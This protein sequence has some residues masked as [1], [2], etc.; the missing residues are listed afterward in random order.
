MAATEMR[1]RLG[2]DYKNGL[3]V[4]T[5]H[6]LANYMLCSAGIDT[7][8]IINEEKF[9]RLFE[10]VEAH[11]NAV[12]HLDW[13]LLDEAQDT[14]ALQFK[15]L[16]KMINPDYFF[17]I[18]DLRQSIYRWRG[19]RPDL[20]KTMMDRNDVAVY[21]LTENYRNGANI[22]SFA[23][24][25]IKKIGMDDNSCPMR[26]YRGIVGEHPYNLNLIVNEVNKCFAYKDCAVIARENKTVN[27]VVSYLKMNGIPCES[28]KQ[29]DL[30]KEELTERME[31]DTVKVLTVHAS[32][33]LE[34]P[35]VI[36][37]GMRFWNEEEY[38]VA[39]VA[40]TRARDQLIWMN[41]PSKKRF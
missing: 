24:R 12:K 27:E 15:F 1:E 4:G 17:I 20:L 2:E 10:M 36:A 22:L 41:A 28:F 38:N 39:Y 37:I 14:D 18:G 8:K 13:I 21:D 31:S 34:W 11:P 25:I 32:K 5:I 23:K 26:E 9:D 19:A 33:G 7:K 16:F 29:G 3:F 40:A 35:T 6:G 30:T